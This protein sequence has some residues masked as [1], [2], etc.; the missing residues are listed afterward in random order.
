MQSK[1]PPCGAPWKRLKLAKN[2]LNLYVNILYTQKFTRAFA[3]TYIFEYLA[4]KY[5]SMIEK[6]AYYIS[7]KLVS[8]RICKMWIS[9]K[10]KQLGFHSKRVFH[11]QS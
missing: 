9:L 7:G 10:Q 6:H 2:L 4:Y 3:H 8:S 11:L 5:I 1:L